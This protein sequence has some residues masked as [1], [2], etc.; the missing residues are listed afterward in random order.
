MGAVRETLARDTTTGTLTYAAD[1][2]DSTLYRLSP[3]SCLN[4]RYR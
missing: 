2:A 3:E 4:S 1:A